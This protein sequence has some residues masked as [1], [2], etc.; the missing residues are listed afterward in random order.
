M[1]PTSFKCTFG[2]YPSNCEDSS[3]VIFGV[4][5]YFSPST[6]KPIIEPVNLLRIYSYEVED[7]SNIYNAF[8]SEVK[9]CD[10]GDIVVNDINEIEIDISTIIHHCK[11]K[12][13]IPVM[14]GGD[15]T[16]T[17]YTVKYLKPKTLIVLDAH[18]D[19]REKFYGEKFNHATFMRKVCEEGHVKKIYYIGVRAFSDEEMRYASKKK[20]IVMISDLEKMSWGNIESP[21]YLSLDLDVVDPVHMKLVATSEPLGIDPKKLFTLFRKISE[22][23][24]IGLDIMEF[25]P[26]TLDIPSIILAVKIIFEGLLTLWFSVKDS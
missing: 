23:E 19:L 17:Y 10:I 9:A 15:H 25:T 16:F 24:I 20:N 13:K 21:V 4:P 2:G 12:R 6:I 14:L 3:I 1:W 26:Y 5:K 18:L 8:Y 11:K 7:Y 22:I